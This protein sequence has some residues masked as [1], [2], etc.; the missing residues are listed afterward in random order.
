M[1][2][3][4]KYMTDKDKKI[5]DIEKKIA[6]LKAQKQALVQR[7]KE[8]ERKARTKRLIEMGAILESN[9]EISSPKE[10]KV[11]C[12]YLKKYPANYDKLKAYVKKQ[13][14]APEGT[15]VEDQAEE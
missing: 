10:V 8:K 3:Q 4:E 6:Q 14:D 5:E 12:D 15:V 9:L 11:L 1:E 2:D 13:M 7:E